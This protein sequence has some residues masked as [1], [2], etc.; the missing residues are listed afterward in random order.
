LEECNG[1]E[2]NL[3]GYQESSRL[4]ETI[5]SSSRSGAFEF[6]K[7]LNRVKRKK[8]ADLLFQGVSAHT[9]ESLLLALMPLEANHNVCKGL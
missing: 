5:F 9:I 1:E 4:V 3:L 2:T 6:L 7:K 8:R